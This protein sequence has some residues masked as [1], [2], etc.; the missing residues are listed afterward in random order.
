MDKQREEFEKA[1]RR[2]ET[3]CVMFERGV[4]TLDDVLRSREE[5]L[6]FAH[7]AQPA[8]PDE[9]RCPLCFDKGSAQMPD[10]WKLEFLTDVTTA[11][12]LLGYG[13]QDK[14]LAKRIGAGAYRWR[15]ELFDAAPSTK[16]PGK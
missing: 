10:G 2:H 1:L 8:H 9:F 12:G 13:K 6:Q 14:G 4:Q 16:E 15:S 11:A 7:A 3:N 5:F